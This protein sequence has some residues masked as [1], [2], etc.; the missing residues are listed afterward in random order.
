[1]QRAKGEA[2]LMTKFNHKS[3]ISIF[4]PCYV[5]VRYHRLILIMELANGGSL[6][7]ALDS[8]RYD[9]I[10]WSEDAVAFVLKAILEGVQELHSLGIVHRDVKTANICACLNGDLK[11]IDYGLS[12]QVTADEP[13]FVGCAGTAHYMPPE[14]CM[15]FEHGPSA[16]IWS[17]GVVAIVCTHGAPPLSDETP[18]RAMA[19]TGNYLYDYDSDPTAGLGFNNHTG[20]WSA[21]LRDF[22]TQ[23]LA[24]DAAERPSAAALLNHPFLRQTASQASMAKLFAKAFSNSEDESSE[25]ES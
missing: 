11:I 17:V 18:E 25:D 1:M 6:Q 9:G 24:V 15:G 20:P 4:A 16:D 22:I 12:R 23:A 8:L 19:I 2:I 3:L 21:D 10:V 14:V 5:D 7:D 13:V